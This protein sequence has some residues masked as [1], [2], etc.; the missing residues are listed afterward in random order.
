M[1]NQ[2][3]VSKIQ[4]SWHDAQR[5]DKQDMD[6]EQTRNVQI[7]AATINNHFGSG[8]LP[9]AP[10]QPILFDSDNLSS[11]QAALLAAGDFDGTGLQAHQQPS[12]SNLGNQLEVE[13]TGGS[14]FGRLCTKV[15]IMGLDFEGSPQL[16]R[17][18]FYR[19]EVQ[20]TRKHYT[21]ILGIF[22]VD[23]KGNN[24]CSRNLGGRITIKETLSY[25]LS[26]DAV[27]IAQ[28]VEPDLFFRDFKVSQA[29]IGANPTVTL[30][31]T[32]Q[33]GIGSEYSVDSFNINTTP[34]RQLQINANDVTTK[35]GQKFIANTNNIQKITLLLGAGRND[36]VSIEHRYD[37]SGDIVVSV[38]AL[39]TT[40]ACPS[41]LVPELNIEFDP[42]SQPLAQLSFSR[43]ELYDNGYILTDT[44]Q[45]VDFV[46]SGTQ[47]GSTTSPVI[48]PNRYYVVTINRAGA[49][50]TGQILTASGG[51]QIDN[52]RLTLYSGS[53]VDVAE[54]DLWFQVWT[55]AA[56]VAS[57]QA[58]DAG[59]GMIVE[60]TEVNN[61]GATV[62]YVLGY[63][64]FSNS[65]ENILNTGIVEATL[66]QTLEEQDE[67][68]GNPIYTREQYSPSFSFVTSSTLT[69]LR[70]SGDPLIIGCAQDSNPKDN[71]E[72]TGNQTYPGLVKGDTFTVVSPGPD[73][74]SQMLIGSKLIPND[75]CEAKSYRIFKTTYCT[76]GFGDVNGDGTIDA[77]DIARATVLIG[78]GLAST[79]TQQKIVDGYIGTLEILRAD[80]DGD[81]YV[82]ANDVNLISAYVARTSNSF[83][84]GSSFNHLELQVQQSVGRYDGYFDC[85]GYIRLDGYAGRVIVAPSDLNP[86]ELL[87]DGYITEPQMDTDDPV[88]NTIPFVTVPY[89]ILPQPFWQDYLLAFSSEARQVLATF[90]YNVGTDEPSCTTASHFTCTDRMDVSQ[91]CDPGRNDLMIPDNLIMRR[92]KIL[93]SDGE[94]YKQDIEVNHI[95]LNL[96]QIPLTEEHLNIFEKFVADA[97][98]GFT[99]AGYPAMRFSDCTTVPLTALVNNQVRF[100]VSVQA[101]VPN[102]DGYGDDGYGVIVDPII[103]TYLDHTTGILTLSMKD[104]SVSPVYMTLVT[105]IQVTVYLKQAGWNNDVL[106]VSSS[107]VQGL[108]S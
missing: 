13:L 102:L 103:G 106:I 36:A 2:L 51:S 85:D 11:I 57:G 25:Q 66:E 93:S 73:L 94:L 37:W 72:I 98:D 64:A 46:F 49:A 21:R 83:P 59:N 27:M 70:S 79:L 15:L 23:F 1:T 90:S 96:P 30:Y 67:R 88:F 26:R 8:V 99:A 5:V 54:E 105:K 52:S 4:N 104:L 32:L 76:D 108:L 50:G 56:K 87:Y 48:V 62:D 14:V 40:V 84:V 65:G 20:V 19:N 78:E 47:L 63:Q 39:Q 18:Y 12:D 6:T 22:F 35:I 44:L 58:Y 55:D 45:P 81:G 86:W 60:K 91:S 68:T 100:G 33:Q 7:D 38:Y 24:N 31:Q 29:T 97:G 95:I 17:F 74:L 42:S 10:T 75:N 69:T 43:T 61:L 41:E 28:D 107:Q 71:E 80:V 53:W 101:F 3:P 82:T 92:G 89:K 16:D 9:A 34:K 77:D